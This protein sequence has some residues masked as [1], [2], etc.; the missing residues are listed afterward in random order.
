M[1]NSFSSLSLPR[2]FRAEYKSSLSYIQPDKKWRGKNFFFYI[3]NRISCGR[4]NQYFCQNVKC[5]FCVYSPDFGEWK[6]WSQDFALETVR[7]R[8]PSPGSRDIQTFLQVNQSFLLL[9]LPYY[10]NSR[11]QMLC[12]LT[13]R[14]VS[15][16]SL[17]DLYLTNCINDKKWAASIHNIV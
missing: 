8:V 3:A 9:F 1:P 6:S 2:R 14:F 12:T 10:A 17:F 11:A 4:R 13:I 7:S 16:T 15:K 5:F